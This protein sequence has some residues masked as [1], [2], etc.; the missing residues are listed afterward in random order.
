MV[1]VRQDLPSSI[2]MVAVLQIEEDGGLSPPE[3]PTSIP[4]MSSS[5]GSHQYPQE[6]HINGVIP[7]Q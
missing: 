2:T 6:G 1:G 3:L 5:R 7:G 4:D